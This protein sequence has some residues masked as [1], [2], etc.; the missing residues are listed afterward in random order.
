MPPDGEVPPEAPWMALADGLLLVR[1]QRPHQFVFWDGQSYAV[2][3][4]RAHLARG[5]VL[6]LDRISDPLKRLSVAEQRIVSGELGDERAF[7]DGLLIL[8]RDPDDPP[9]ARKTR[10]HACGGHQSPRID[11]GRRHT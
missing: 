6:P 10:A 1:G 5:E 4:I 7:V 8:A 11:C 3:A 2:D 9:R